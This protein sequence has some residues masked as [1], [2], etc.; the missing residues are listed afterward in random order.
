[1]LANKFAN[2]LANRGAERVGLR[3]LDFYFGEKKVDKMEN[4]DLSKD[5]STDTSA[6][7]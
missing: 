3:N 5:A 2:K 4:R 1:M 6:Y 7:Q